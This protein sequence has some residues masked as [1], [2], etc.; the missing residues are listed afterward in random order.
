[1]K[2]SNVILSYLN[3]LKDIEEKYKSLHEDLNIKHQLDIFLLEQKYK[4]CVLGWGFK[5]SIIRQY[6][7]EKEAEIKKKV[8]KMEREKEYAKNFEEKKKIEKGL[9]PMKEEL[10]QVRTLKTIFE[11]KNN[12]MEDAP[13][14]Y[15]SDSGRNNGG[16]N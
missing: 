9:F 16:N 12:D 3:E 11:L 6:L 5:R 10:N 13:V 4:N 2:D 15:G 8:S 1:M 7:L 14:N